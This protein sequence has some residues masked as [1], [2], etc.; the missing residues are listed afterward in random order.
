MT[1]RLFTVLGKS[2]EY[3]HMQNIC[4][5]KWQLFGDPEHVKRRDN[6]QNKYANIEYSNGTDTYLQS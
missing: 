2:F 5:P 3:S 4:K 6:E 1:E